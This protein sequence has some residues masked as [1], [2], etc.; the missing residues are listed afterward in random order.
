MTNRERLISLLESDLYDEDIAD[1]IS[2]ELMS[3]TDEDDISIA[4]I[5]GNDKKLLA[6]WLG[7]E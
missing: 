6:E 2:D 7:K 3:I 5:C 4:V 1:V